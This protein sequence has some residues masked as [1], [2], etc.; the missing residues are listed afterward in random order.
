MAEFTGAFPAPAWTPP[1]PEPFVPLRPLT[2]GQILAGSF[3]ALR[4]NPGVTLVPAIVVSI[5]ATL[6][7]TAFGIL[8]VEP[9]I[10]AVGSGYG[11]VSLYGWVSGYA[12]GA[13]GWVVT[14]SLGLGAGAAQQGVSAVDVAHAVIGRRLT[15]GGFRRRMR[16]V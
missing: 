5:V 15:P 12:A 11:S 1:A 3:R 7:G 6:G 9:L 13:L 10:S 8:V 14:Q 16:G 2:L 4:H